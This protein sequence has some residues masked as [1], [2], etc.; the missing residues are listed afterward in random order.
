MSTSDQKKIGA[1]ILAAGASSRMGSPK[2]LLDYHGETFIERLVRV[3]S[4]VCDPVIVALGYHA[5]AIRP[6]VKAQV[7]VNPAPE[8][9][10]LTSLQTALAALPADLDGFLFIPVDCPAVEE[11]TVRTA[12]DTFRK[13]GSEVQFVVPQYNGKHGHPVCADASL[14]A[15]FLAL[16]EDGQARHIVHKYVPQTV[17]VDVD[18]PGILTDVDDPEAYRRMMAEKR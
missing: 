15:E 13:R 17:Y 12:I 16:P 5:D 1:I 11:S 8:R 18:D 7:A 4:S 14:I 6:K 3:F 2:A 9:G 10:M